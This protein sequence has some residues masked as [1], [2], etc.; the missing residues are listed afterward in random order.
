MNTPTKEEIITFMENLVMGR[1]SIHE[2]NQKLS[3]LFGEKIELYN[4]S[5]GRIDNGED[6][7]ELADWNLMVN[8]IREDVYELFLDIYV[9]PTREFDNENNIKYYV[10]EV[11]YDFC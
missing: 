9:L 11:G 5:Q 8:T 3:D 2:L 10:T 7:D 4:S 6:S 1:F